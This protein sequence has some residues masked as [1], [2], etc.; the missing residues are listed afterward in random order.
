MLGSVSELD[1][2][3]YLFFWELSSLTLLPSPCCKPGLL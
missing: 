2:L 1:V 3:N